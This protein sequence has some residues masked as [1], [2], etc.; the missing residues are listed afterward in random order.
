[1]KKSLQIYLSVLVGIMLVAGV[2]Y[3][4]FTDRSKILGS[5]FTMGSADIKLLD[6]L[7][8]G[9]GSD[10]LLDEKPGPT[11]SGISPN[12]HQD[13]LLKVYN[14]AGSALTLNATTAYTTAND[15]DDLRSIIFAEIFDWNDAN[16][17]GIVEEGELGTSHGRQTITRWKN[18]GGIN[19]G[20]LGSGSVGSYVIRFSTDNISDTK[21][22]KS[23]LFDFEISSASL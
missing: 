1:M 21:Q 16:S 2:C 19:L 13:Y 9:T 6:N 12:W 10:N 20:Q 3:A 4:A 5:T 17:N 18:D 22:G 14:N 8:G 7:A 15:P 11:F 23:A